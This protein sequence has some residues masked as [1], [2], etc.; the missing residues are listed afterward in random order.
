MAIN[1]TDFSRAPILE[2][3]V[4][5][6][7]ED[8]LK[9]YQIAKEPAKMQDDAKT[10]ALVNSLKEKALAHKD[11]QY[12]LDDSLKRAQIHKA[13]Q[14][15]ALKGALAQAMQLR[16]SLDPKSPSYE[17]DLGE[18]T[19]YINKLG[20]SSKGIQVSST[21][22]GGVQVSIGGQGETASLPGLP[23][24]KTGETYIMDEQKQPIGV[25]K[26]YSEA[27]KKEATGREFFNVVQP[28]LNTSQSYYSGRDSTK[29]FESDVLNYS[30]DAAAKQRI[31]NLLAADKLLFSG[32]VKENATLGG[33]NTN[34]VYE[35]LTKSLQNSEVYPLLKNVAKYQLPSGYSEASGAIFNEMLNKGTEAGQGLPAYKISYFN[36]QNKKDAALS[37]ALSNKKSTSLA[38]PEGMKSK[39]YTL[40]D[41][42]HTAKVHK[43]TPEQVIAQ[44]EKSH[45]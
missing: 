36:K 43:I 30:T 8:A 28:F 19:N 4:K 37:N 45:A 25:G 41:I 17:R 27:E 2:S 33:A 12:A 23:K 40:E 16:S 7:F 32:V 3:P 44:W 29:R 14:P 38:I 13:N 10:R 5:N 20:T 11:M 21:P 39:G 6:V 22:E 18:V 26:P 31:D 42:E 15:A 34:K 24:L 9:G 35:R 1:F